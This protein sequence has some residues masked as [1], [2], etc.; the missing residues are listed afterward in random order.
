MTSYTILQVPIGARLVYD[1]TPGPGTLVASHSPSNSG[2][3]PYGTPYPA[4]DWCAEGYAI[5][6]AVWPGASLVRTAERHHG[7]QTPAHGPAEG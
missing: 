7:P 6:Y 3:D 2:T 1:G 5:A 4:G